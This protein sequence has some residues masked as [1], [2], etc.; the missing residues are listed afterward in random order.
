M[1]AKSRLRARTS[2]VL[3]ASA[4]VAVAA[5]ALSSV[6]AL[7]ATLPGGLGPCGG[8]DCPDPFPDNGSG[9]I[10]GYDD[11]VNVFVG[12]D[13]SVTGSAAESEGRNV[14]LGD[15]DQNKTSG[16]A[17]YNVG[18][19][20]V[21]SRVPPPTGSDYMQV[22]GSLTIATEQRLLAEEGAESGV[23]RV[24]GTA[25]GEV[26][27]TAVIDSAA[28]DEYAG[29][30]DELTEASLCYA[31]PEDATRRATTGTVDNQGFQTVF[32][33]DGSSALQ[34]FAVD[35]GLTGAGG[36]MQS[37]VFENIPAGATVLV[38]LYGDT[39]TLNLNNTPQESIRDRLLWNF[40]EATTVNLQGTTQLQGSV[41]AGSQASTTTLSMSGTNGRMFLTGNLVH[42]SSTLPG[43]GQEIHNYPFNGDLPECE[44]VDPT[45]TTDAPT[46]DE[47]TTDEPTTD[48]PTSDGP[49]TD[50]PTTDG[51]TTDGPTTDGPTT[52]GPTTDAPTT[53]VPTSG[54]PTTGTAP[55]TG[56]ATSPDGG[57]GLPLTGTRL[58]M[59][60]GVG[61]GALA[62]GVVVLATTRRRRA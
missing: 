55:T 28:V 56:E 21:G 62:L 20:G 46:S 45:D 4:A 5:F 25:T 37:V 16:S 39:V 34:V 18:I 43:S 19:A 52:D 27:P 12:G 53:A 33:G 7:A 58:L 6:E 41:L 31:Y 3:A 48:A 23:V 32:T 61:V 30:R 35:G 50:E 59:A 8:P 38:N 29:L 51:P 14:V 9:P 15:F 26:I 22:G 57:G 44:D 42:G 47:P 60:V 40:P 24:A 2:V 10:A 11:S 49:T 17:V 36:G 54:G 1:P 13:F